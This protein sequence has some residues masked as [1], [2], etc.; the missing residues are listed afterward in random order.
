MIAEKA[1]FRSARKI[2]RAI[3][4]RI[5]DRVFNSAFLEVVP[6]AMTNR[7]LPQRIREQLLNIHHDFLACK[8]K[9]NPNCGCP[10]RKFAKTILEYRETGLDHRQISEALLEEYGIEVF[11]ADILGF[12]EETVHALEVVREVARI[13]GKTDLVKKTDDHIRAVER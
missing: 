11:P 9:D 10:E 3:G 8:C 4:V 1:R 2:E 13:E 7:S 6:P 5:P 12:L